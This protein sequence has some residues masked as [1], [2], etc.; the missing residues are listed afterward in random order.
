MK[1]E[2]KSSN[3]VSIDYDEQEQTLIIEFPGGSKYKY[4]KMPVREYKNFLNAES[5]GKYFHKHI[6]SNYVGKKITLDNQCVGC[7]YNIGNF[8]SLF[9]RIVD[10]YTSCSYFTEKLPQKVL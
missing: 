10:N 5:K 3:I 4:D 1:I 7:N 9:D 6:R 2:V 8:C